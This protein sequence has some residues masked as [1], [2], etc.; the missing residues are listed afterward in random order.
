MTE[1]Y[2]LSGV[3]FTVR[4]VELSESARPCT[5]EVCGLIAGFDT[6]SEA[7]LHVLEISR[8]IQEKGVRHEVNVE[9]F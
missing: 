8:E 6:R 1:T 5:V 4:E 2:R 9:R 3:T 7:L